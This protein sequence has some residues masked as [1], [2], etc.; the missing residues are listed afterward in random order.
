MAPSPLEVQRAT[1]GAGWAFGILATFV[2]LLI[3]CT[4][5]FS[6][7]RVFLLIS[8]AITIAL[9][10]LSTWAIHNEGAGS[11]SDA[12]DAQRS[13]TLAKVSSKSH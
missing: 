11:H 2:I 9:L 8:W 12:I 13:H 7:G 5:K 10:V 6:L 3:F 1:L 4:P